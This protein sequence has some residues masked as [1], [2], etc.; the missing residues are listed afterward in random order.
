MSKKNNLIS[1]FRILFTYLII[2]F[3]FSC[4]YQPL[5]KWG[6]SCGFYIVVDFFFIVSGYLLYATYNSRP[7]RYKSGAAYTFDRIKKIGPYYIVS[8]FL[9]FL[10]MVYRDGIKM[11]VYIYFHKFFELI[12]LHAIGLNEGWTSINNSTWYISALIICGFIIYQCLCKWHD[13]FV[14]FWAPILIMICISFIYRNKGSLSASMDTIG[15]FGNLALFRGFSEMCL[16]MYAYMITKKIEERFEKTF[17]FQLSGA[18]LLLGVCVLSLKKNCSVCDFLYLGLIFAGVSFCFL[19]SKSKILSCK[20]IVKWADLSMV[21]YLTHMLFADYVMPTFFEVPAETSKKF[22]LFLICSIF[23]TVL[24]VL[25]FYLGNKFK[26]AGQS[27][28]TD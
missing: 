11:A 23:T 1:I 24:S 14:K 5:D 2:F 27:S 17:L 20:F 3:H 21:I 16:G 10:F 8:Y 28:T 15:V 4:H 9:I 19:T 26:S 18:L 7:D 25:L 22:L 13:S 12:G 6:L